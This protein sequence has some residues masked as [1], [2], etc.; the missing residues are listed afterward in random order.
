MG[1]RSARN[2]QAGLGSYGGPYDPNYGPEYY[3][4]AYEPYGASCKYL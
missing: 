4:G 3:G 2:Q 1:N